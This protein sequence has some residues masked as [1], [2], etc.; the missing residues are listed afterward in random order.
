[1]I[2][3]S[4]GRSI[5]RRPVIECR[6]QAVIDAFVAHQGV[7]DAM[8]S[9]DHHYAADWDAGTVVL[10]LVPGHGM[11]WG[12]WRAGIMGLGDMWN[13]FKAVEMIFSLRRAGEDLVLGSGYL[14]FSS[15]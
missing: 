5:P 6:N 12:V 7:D 3:D 10:S 15:V 4:Y 9:E 11:T 2:F 14:A 8:S 13:D 1:M